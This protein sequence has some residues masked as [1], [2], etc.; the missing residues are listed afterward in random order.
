M[1]PKKTPPKQPDT[2]PKV[3]GE[4]DYDA[5][6]GWFM[7][8]NKVTLSDEQPFAEYF[9]ELTRVPKLAET[10][11]RYFKPRHD[12]ELGF[13]MELVLEALHQSL[14]L[15]RED[16]DSTITF[17]ELVKFNVLRTVR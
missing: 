2:P 6:V 14:R 10:A 11:K 1:K 15:A 4:V 13:G 12:A 16:L 9:R 17:S 3:A 7:E 5:I 8:G